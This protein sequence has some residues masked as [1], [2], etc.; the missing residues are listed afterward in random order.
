MRNPQ[1]NHPTTKLAPLPLV[2]VCGFLGAGKTT[3]MRRLILDAAQRGLRPAVIVNEFG[4]ADVDSHILSEADAEL[5]TAISGGCACCSGQD[6]LRYTL[7]ELANRPVG[8]RAG[9]ILMEAS[10]LADPVLLLEV[11]TSSELLSL[12]RVA[13][14]VAVADAARHLDLVEVLGPLLHRQLQLADVIVLNKT[15]VAGEK[16]ASVET[17]LRHINQRAYLAPAVQADCDLSALWAPVLEENAAHETSGTMPNAAPHA[18]YHTVVCPMPHP[19]ARERLEAALVKLGPQ[20][21]RVKGFVRVR[22][23]SGWQLLQYTGG[24]SG[25]RWHLAP[26]F[27]PQSAPEPEGFLV[28]IGA[29]LDRSQLMQDFA[30]TKL[31]AMM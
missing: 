6:D 21:W 7:H 22:G 15:D 10:G 8:E 20:V 12:V 16:A 5:I 23:L 26:F 29:A 2:L 3:L 27:L 11:A 19:V 1:Q 24:K 9:V 31:L 17:A 4:A 14:I 25:G 13:T 28:F 30:G 18:Q